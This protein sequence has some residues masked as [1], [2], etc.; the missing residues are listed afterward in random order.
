MITTEEI[1]R[2]CETLQLTLTGREY[3]KRVA[4][5][6]PSRRARSLGTNVVSRF[7]SRK[8]GFVVQAESHRHE[9]ALVY[10]LEHDP[11]VIA[12][13]DQPEALKI[14]YLSANGRPTS[15]MI[16]PDYL[17]VGKTGIEWIEVKPHDALPELAKEMPYR[18]VLGDD[19]K[20][21]CPPAQEVAKTYGFNYR[22]WTSKD[23]DPIWLRNIELLADYFGAEEVQIP[24]EVTKRL[25]ELVCAEPGITVAE[26]RRRCPEVTAD[27]M[28]FTLARGMVYADFT[29]APLTQ[30]EKVRLYSTREVAEV[31]QIVRDGKRCYVNSHDLEREFKSG[32]V[33]LWNGRRHTVG[34]L[35]QQKVT[36]LSDGQPLDVNRDEFARLANE[37][38]I[39]L[40]E[41]SFRPAL[42]PEAS[43]LLGH[44]SREDLEIAVRRLRWLQDLQAAKSGGLSART[45][46]RWGRALRLAESRF[47][48]GLLGLLPRFHARGNRNQRFSDALE[49]LIQKIIDEVY[50]T[51]ARPNKAYAH[52]QLRLACEKQGFPVP[53]YAIFTKRIRMRDKY[54][55][56][57]AREGKRV[58]H[59]FE[60]IGQGQV[61]DNHG[62][63][64]WDVVYADHTQADN[65]TVCAE[66]G[67]NLG[68]PWFSIL[69]DGFSRRNLAFVLSPDPPSYRTL[70]LLFRR[71]VERHERL[72]RTL[73]IDGGAEFRSSYFERLAGA[74][75]VLLKRRPPGKPRF[76]C[77]IERMF[78][79]INTSF[80][81]TLQGN[82]QNT[83]NIRQM[84][85]SMD[86]KGHAVWTLEALHDAL[87]EFLFVSYDRRPHSA[88]NT[89]PAEKYRLGMEIAGARSHQAVA[90]DEYFYRLTLPSTR[91][92][93]AKIQP[94]MGVKIFGSYYW[95]P[96]MRDERVE[97]SSVDVHYDPENLGVAWARISD[98][99]VRCNYHGPLNLEGRTEKE[100]KI[101]TMEWRR[102]R[103][104]LGQRQS[105]SKVDF[106]IFLRSAE[107]NV[108]VQTQQAKDRA[109]RRIRQSGSTNGNG[110]GE[111]SHTVLSS[112]LEPQM[113]S[114]PPTPLPAA[115]E[116]WTIERYGDF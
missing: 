101:A 105:D 81:H 115:M 78:G 59:K 13:W 22:I 87:S 71:C 36:L 96:E 24:A 64:P 44:A 103:Q 45:L 12:Y 107:A 68:R 6:P 86:P 85:K 30:P 35:S 5:S 8:M 90:N 102:S 32:Y 83:R 26:V 27:Q 43:E 70:M 15:P 17:A 112:K 76:G 51:A 93:T 60:L 69:L 80:L 116:S 21:S 84:P 57:L 79:T 7:P 58:A 61:N 9:L 56:T 20:W 46:R 72:P 29:F 109:F 38:E 98:R 37:G 110:N 55:M 74:C 75:C 91:K 77:V 4:S 97:G 14:T 42:C 10:V 33:C 67:V 53:S 88:F 19:G 114:Q 94:G 113:E 99:W 73:V 31:Y 16:T 48:H 111:A 50:C 2:H 106:A 49:A 40:I 82:T 3:L 65:E 108:K 54:R 62:Q 41:N 104:G 66:T 92:G 63:Y 100:M 52:L 47:G 39:I 34:N 23:V 11:E 89:S 18:F 28:N 25:Q 1:L 95:C